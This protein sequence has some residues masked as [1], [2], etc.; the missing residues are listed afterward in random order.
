MTI[1]DDKAA[2]RAQMR[3]ERQVLLRSG[4]AP[5]LACQIGQHILAW[6][7]KQTPQTLASYCAIGSEPD[8]TSTHT[9]IAGQNGWSLALPVVQPGEEL[10]VFKA[11]RGG[12]AIVQGPHKTL[13][14]ESKALEVR[15]HTV[16]MPLLAFDRA[17]SRLGQGGGYY[18]RALTALRQTQPVLAIGVAFAC[19]EVTQV[20]TE[21]HDAA[22]D[23][24]VTEH[25]LQYST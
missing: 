23:A 19:Q 14:P 16:L 8:I 5:E 4:A 12:D 21:A 3:A 24:V 7:T 6:T 25:G 10:M 15:P 1:A 9:Q 17:G 2:L 13:Q 20:P 22:L 18:D 11:W